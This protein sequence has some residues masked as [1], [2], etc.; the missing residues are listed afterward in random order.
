MANSPRPEQRNIWQ[1][2]VHIGADLH[3]ETALVCALRYF[4][5]IAPAVVV[6]WAEQWATREEGV[7]AVIDLA[8]LS[9][10]LAHDVDGTLDCLAEQVGLPP[11]TTEDAIRTVS[12]GVARRLERGETTPHE[13]ARVLRGLA[14]VSPV[15][16]DELSG[17]VYFASE[18]EDDEPRRP[19]YEQDIRRACRRLLDAAEGRRPTTSHDEALP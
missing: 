4:D 1:S 12:I 11:I 3:E 10:P 17:F 6:R 7:G 9:D 18:W 14:H 16:W 2:V 13:S 5:M 19:E 15:T 8:I